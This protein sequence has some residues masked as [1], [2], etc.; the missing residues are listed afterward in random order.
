MTLTALIPIR[1]ESTRLPNKNFRM[2]QETPLF[3]HMLLRLEALDRIHRIV[4]NTDSAVVREFCES[5][6][7]KAFIVDRPAHLSGAQITMNAL[8]EHDISQVSE[9]H[10]LQTHCTNPLL[11]TQT[12]VRAIDHYFDHLDRFDSLLT[13]THIRKRAYTSTGKPINHTTDELLETQSLNPIAV[14]NSNLFL[15]SRTSFFE[16]KK[17]RIGKCPSLFAMNALEAMDIDYEED[18]HLAQLIANNKN[19]FTCFGAPMS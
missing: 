13:T 11:T 5:H 1:S 19:L 12:I 7:S 2:F 15:F 18:L 10:F 9:E 3:T 6:I 8:I 14:E 4:V 17:S 16:N